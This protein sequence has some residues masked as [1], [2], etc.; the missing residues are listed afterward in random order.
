MN[1]NPRDPLELADSE[2][3]EY[4]DQEREEM[5]SSPEKEFDL[6]NK[7]F[8]ELEK[9]ISK[10]KLNRLRNKLEQESKLP[11]KVAVI[12]KAGVGK[13]TTINNLFNADLKT[14]PTTV[15][16]TQAQT[17]EFTLS[18]GGTLTVIDFPGYGRSEK[19]DQD[20]EK[21]YQD[22]IPD[23]DI[24]LLVLQADAKDFTDDI[25]MIKKIKKWVQACPNSKI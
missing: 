2:A 23:C 12:G 15:G 14:S 20:Y 21:I 4:A 17:K 7:L 11:P 10:D 24:I 1:I 8:N 22:L 13:T 16:T 19:E 3:K 9:I 6:Q 18:A 5:R 25:E